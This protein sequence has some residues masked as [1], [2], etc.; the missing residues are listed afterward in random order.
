M[1]SD[2]NGDEDDSPKLWQ[3]AT[4]VN[5]TAEH[6][7]SKDDEARLEDGDDDNS[8]KLQKAAMGATITGE[9]TCPKDDKA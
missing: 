2:E 4:E 8:I 6:K 1:G 3:I 7:S 5:M 9:Q